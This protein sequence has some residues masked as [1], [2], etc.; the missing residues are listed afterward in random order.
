[1]GVRHD[2]AIKGRIF[3]FLGSSSGGIE[4]DWRKNFYRIGAGFPFTYSRLVF[5]ARQW[6]PSTPINI[7]FGLWILKDNFGT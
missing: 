7:N 4:Y 3:A 5:L 1:M 6:V 2:C